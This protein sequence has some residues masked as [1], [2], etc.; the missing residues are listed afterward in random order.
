M[1]T[2]NSLVD[3]LCAVGAANA[4]QDPICS[5]SALERL[6][7][8][9]TPT[10]W[11]DDLYTADAEGTI[12]QRLRAVHMGYIERRRDTEPDWLESIRRGYPA[13]YGIQ[14]DREWSSPARRSVLLA[15][16]PPGLFS[17]FEMSEYSFPFDS[18]A[19]VDL[20]DSYFNRPEDLKEF[21]NYRVDYEGHREFFVCTHGH[22]DIC[23]A[24]FGIPL[25]NQARAAYPKVR[26]WRTTHF[27]GHRFAPTA[28]EFPSGYKWA[29]LDNETTQHV[30][31]RDSDAATLALNVRGWSG[32]ETYA[33]VLDREGL[34]Q[35][36]WDWLQFKRRG[37]LEKADDEAKR[38]RV[39]LDF[40]SPAG[41]SGTYT[42][43]VV[44]KREL[45]NFGCG[46]HYGD[47]DHMMPEY[48]LESFS[49]T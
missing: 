30:L 35:Y 23:C 17:N 43:T 24:K 20:A 14:P 4:G 15:I 34:K 26:A 2:S 48:S 47:Y 13:F 16:R 45:E 12:Q 3:R 40:E 36:G 27:G 46:P 31:E 28:W 11:G 9:E 21:E 25:Y 6:L 32:A 10:P 22:V 19:L 41:D 49:V 44:V 39:R 1:T 7:I 29:F 8:I 42:G 5:G 37:V 33:Q 18:P 38:W